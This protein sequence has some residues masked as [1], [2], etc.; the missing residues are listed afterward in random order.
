LNPLSSSSPLQPL[1]QPQTLQ[2]LRTN[3]SFNAPITQLNPPSS[4]SPSQPLAQPQTLRTNSN[5]SASSLSGQ[6][7]L[8]PR[9]RQVPSTILDFQLELFTIPTG[10]QPKPHA[11]K[12]HVYKIDEPIEGQG[13][14]TKKLTRQTSFSDFLDREI[15]KKKGSFL[16]RLKDEKV[17]QEIRDAFDE[18]LT[19]FEEPHSENAKEMKKYLLELRAHMKANLGNLGDEARALICALPCAKGENLKD[20]RGQSQEKINRLVNSLNSVNI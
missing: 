7:A 16:E 18:L 19:D 15:Q 10:T 5:L 14:T 2:P 6:K 9:S 13:K 20:R 11:H 8:F 4:S 12:M 3:S 17:T 1:A